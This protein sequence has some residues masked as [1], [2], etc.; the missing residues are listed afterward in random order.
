M[1]GPVA[2]SGTPGTGKS[3]VARRLAG[4]LSV[5]EVDAVARRY[6]AA[7]GRGRSVEIDLPRLRR[8]LQRPG[9][10]EGVDLVVG[11]LSHLLPVREAIVLRCRPM[12]LR[13]RLR[14]AR[15][16]TVAD[17]QVNF[18]CEAT[19]VV[20]LEALSAGRTVFEID[21]T[22]R[23]V[24]AVA[25]EVGRRVASGGAPRVGIVDWLADPEVTTHLLGRVR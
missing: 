1:P 12:E 21:T 23:G 25:R 3:S 2:L 9:A 18:V 17:R 13:T 19:D 8:A 4:R 10:W 16:G 11:H 14:R 15:R 5:V 20:L 7:R 24:P 22:G 6:G